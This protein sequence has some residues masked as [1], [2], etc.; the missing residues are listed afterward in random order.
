MTGGFCAAL[1]VFYSSPYVKLFTN[2]LQVGKTRVENLEGGKKAITEI[3]MKRNADRGSATVEATLII[4]LFIFGILSMFH[5]IR[6][7][8]AE[9]V[10]Y[11]AAAETVEYMAELSYIEECNYLVPQT[12]IDDYIDNMDLIDAYI[13][14]GVDGVSFFGSVFL[15][16]EGYLCLKVSYKV[17]ISVPLVGDMSSER[18]YWIRQK[19]YTGDKAETTEEGLSSDEIYVYITDNREAYHASRGCTHLDLS[20]TPGTKTAAIA[21]GYSPC[22][23]CGKDAQKAVLITNY[24]DRYHSRADC[25]GLKRTVYR[26]KKSQVEELGACERCVH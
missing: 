23:F 20:V 16:E 8:M 26:V 12:K 10:L 25:M 15:D 6:A 1:K 24:G 11:E 19:A 3:T 14:G 22:E 5:G 2:P 13:I 9:A 7:R 17:G 4:P 18:S 21:N